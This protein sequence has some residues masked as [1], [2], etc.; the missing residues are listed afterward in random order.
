MVLVDGFA[1]G[2]S[3]SRLPALLHWWVPSL[4]GIVAAA[5]PLRQYSVSRVV[6]LTVAGTGLLVLLDLVGAALESQ[7]ASRWALLGEVSVQTVVAQNVHPES[8]VTTLW[9]W[10]SGGLAGVSE[11]LARYPS[12]HPRVLV[13]KALGEASAVLLAVGTVGLIMA[14]RRWID[15]S[16]VLRRPSNDLIVGAVLGWIIAPS[17]SVAAT[18]LT[19][20]RISAALFSGEPLVTVLLPSAAIA[21]LGVLGLVYA[22]RGAR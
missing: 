14:L 17:M 4:L 16:V 2:A 3:V 8:W 22:L 7:L 11:R 20:T 1:F 19:G 21:L 6:A 13:L 15:R 5:M 9:A 12:A 10:T 18:Q